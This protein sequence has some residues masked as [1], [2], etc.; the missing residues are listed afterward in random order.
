MDIQS[1]DD[2]RS[3][4]LQNFQTK[5]SGLKAQYSTALTAAIQEPD[6]A[7]QSNHVQK[8]LVI[9]QNLVNSIQ[10]I[11][12]ILNDGTKDLD[13]ATIDSLRKD[14]VKYQQEYAALQ[15]SKDILITLQ[16]I[17]A[18]TKGDLTTATTAYNVYLFVLCLMVLIVVFLAIRTSLM[19]SSRNSVSRGF[20]QTY[21]S[22]AAPS[23]SKNI[24][25][26]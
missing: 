2:A 15:Q 4:D 8:I 13:T 14:L 26:Y 10:S 19:T 6:P 3:T 20:G 23:A 9:N 5:Y 12:S 17:Q 16:R 7:S 25:I 21:A 24:A 18:T 11:L 1:F 22:P